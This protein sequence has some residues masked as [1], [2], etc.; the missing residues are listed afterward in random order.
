MENLKEVVSEV[1]KL[2][3]KILIQKVDVSKISEVDDVVKKALDK[4]TKIDILVNNAG[5]TRD[6]LI[7]RM[8]EEEWDQV[9]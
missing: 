9:L 7:L 2:G 3:K 5:I 1:E 6:N 4:F 8:S